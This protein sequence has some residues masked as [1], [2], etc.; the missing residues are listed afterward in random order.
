MKIEIPEFDVHDPSHK[1]S[2]DAVYWPEYRWWGWHPNYPYWSKSCWVAKTELEAWE[3][4]AKTHTG[5]DVYECVLV[6]EH[7][8]EFEVIAKR[9]CKRMDIWNNL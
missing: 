1:K 5:L 7:R 2:Y 4:L 9:H 3:L 8:G 6:K